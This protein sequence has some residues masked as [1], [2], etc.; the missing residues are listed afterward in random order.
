MLKSLK[1]RSQLA[2]FPDFFKDGLFNLTDPHAGQAVDLP[3]A[4]QGVRPALSRDVNA[5]VTL[6]ELDPVR[7]SLPLA[8]HPSFGMY[9]ETCCPVH[10]AVSRVT[11]LDDVEMF[12]AFLHG[13]VTR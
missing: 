8:V 2:H 13:G 4:L 3:D 9:C 7:A 5:V 12:L 10:D 1:L 11:G 6:T